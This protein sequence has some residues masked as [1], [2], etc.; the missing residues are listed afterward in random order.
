MHMAKCLPCA[1]KLS[2]GL[3]SAQRDEGWPKGLRILVRC[4]YQHAWNDAP[5]QPKKKP[6]P[7]AT[8]ATVDSASRQQ[9]DWQPDRT[10]RY[11]PYGGIAQ[12]KGMTLN[13]IM[14]YR[15][16]CR[17]LTGSGEASTAGST[18]AGA[19]LSGRTKQQHSTGGTKRSS[20]G[21]KQ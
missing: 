7:N 10:M 20:K 11:V 14:M 16:Q 13:S 3:S 18:S 5:A 17:Q 2:K 12:E 4:R 8:A 1:L 21:G 9:L 6:V 19:S 15:T